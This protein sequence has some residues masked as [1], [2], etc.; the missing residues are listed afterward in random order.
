VQEK[1]DFFVDILTEKILCGNTVVR[2]SPFNR[3]AF[4]AV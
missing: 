3:P 2:V 4:T 1:G